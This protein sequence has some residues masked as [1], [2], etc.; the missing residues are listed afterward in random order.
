MAKPVAITV[1]GREAV[2]HR[3]ASE[4][5]EIVGRVPPGATITIGKRVVPAGADANLTVWPAFSAGPGWVRATLPDGASGFVSGHE[6]D[7]GPT[8][9]HFLPAPNH[10]MR[11][12]LRLSVVH[13]T[14]LS[15]QV[16]GGLA[17]TT[18]TWR[19]QREPAFAWDVRRPTTGKAK[20]STECP[21]CHQILRGELYSTDQLAR[22][23][24]SHEARGRRLRQVATAILLAAVAVTAFGL[25]FAPA[26]EWPYVGLFVC[27]MGVIFWAAVMVEGT[28]GG[29]GRLGG[30]FEL[31]KSPIEHSGGHYISGIESW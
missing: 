29:P 16:G 8:G 31:D 7:D 30:D 23:R 6:V 19:Y 17:S 5:T 10:Y 9:K 28:G 13:Q 14:H 1:V 27:F 24:G 3:K 4:A 20:V 26:S 15:V 21:H 25:A 12:N 22:L 18:T 2:V 11:E